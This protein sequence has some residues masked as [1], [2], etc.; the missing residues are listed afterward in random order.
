[1]ELLANPLGHPR[2]VHKWLVMRRAPTINQRFMQTGNFV[3]DT[4]HSHRRL[5]RLK[6]YDYSQAGAYYVTVVTQ[7]RVC[8]F[9][10]IIN[11]EMQLNEAGLLVQRAWNDLPNHYANASLGAFVIMPNHVHGVIILSDVE[12]RVALA[13]R[14]GLRPAHTPASIHASA[15]I[16]VRAEARSS[17]IHALPEIIRAFKSFSARRINENH[18]NIGRSIWQRNY[19]EHVIRNEDEL[20]GIC[21]YIAA[22]PQNWEGDGENIA[23][24]PVVQSVVPR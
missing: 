9:G 13:G 2:T 3:P 1:M 18:N 21:E 10:G 7:A 15:S 11:G 22:N 19:Y 16:T 12:G 6:D 4:T 8:L 5:L 20:N 17:K 14:A 24:I 23:C